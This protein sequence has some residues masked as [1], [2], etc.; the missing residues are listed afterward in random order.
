MVHCSSLDAICREFGPIRVD[1]LGKISMAVLSGLDYLYVQHHIMHRDIKPSN[2]LVNSKGHVKICDFG[3]SS[4]LVNSIANTFVGTS[5]YMAP[6]RIQGGA[7]SI[8][9]DI[10]SFGLTIL[11]LA[12]GNYPF[13]QTARLEDEP[14]K[15]KLLTLAGEEDAAEEPEMIGEEVEAEA[16]DEEEEDEDED[17]DEEDDEDDEEDED[18]EE[19]EE[20]AERGEDEAAT[21]DDRDKGKEV[22]EEQQPYQLPQLDLEGDSEDDDDSPHP[23]G[24]VELLQR[25]VHEPSPRLPKSDAFPSILDAMIQKCLMKKPDERPTPGEILVRCNL[26]TVLL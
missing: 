6:E 13:A 1:V 7:Y 24:I 4:E 25:I 9:S 22:E 10:W 16:D 15:P 8:K 17:E 23:L 18:E 26:Y 2:V 11:E 12:T 5:T 14:S 20:E 19:D 21:H 3:V